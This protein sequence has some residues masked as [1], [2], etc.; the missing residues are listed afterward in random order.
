MGNNLEPT[1]GGALALAELREFASFDPASQRY[2]RR[3]LDIAFDRNDATILWSRDKFEAASIQ[4]QTLVYHSVPYIRD[5]V[6][7]D[8]GVD[9]CRSFLGEL[10]ALTAFDLGQDRLS[11]FGP[12]RFLYERLIGAKARPW[13]PAAFCAAAALPDLHPR[14]RRELLQSISEAAA[15]APGWSP[16][17]PVFV[18][19]WVEKVQ[20]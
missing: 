14:R 7:S 12:Y 1:V 18:P 17:E 3:S 5:V 4:A 10:I 13:L 11:G 6:N 2:I 9:P 15:T 8:Y 19:E 20:V 16:K